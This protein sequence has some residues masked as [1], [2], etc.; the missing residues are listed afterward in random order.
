MKNYRQIII[1]LIIGTVIG[2]SVFEI[3]HE[4]DLFGLGHIVTM[5]Q[6]KHEGGGVLTN[7]LLECSTAE[8]D[9]TYPALNISKP[10]LTSFVNRM[11]STNKIDFISVY[12]RDLNNGPWIGINEKEEFLGS[13]L[14]KVPILISYM[15]SAENDNSLLDKKIKYT[16]KVIDDDQYYS[17]EKVLEVGGEYTVKDLLNYMIYYSD[18]NAANL[19]ADS[20]D[21]SEMDKVFE[22]LGL[23]K[24]VFNTPYPVNVRNYA[25]F[26]RIL[27]NASYVNKEYSEK[28]LEILTHTEFNR[29]LTAF[30]PK[31]IVVAHKF[32]IRSDNGVNQLHDCG[33]V[34]Y[35][36][37]PYLICI[38]SRGRNFDDLASAIAQISEF[39][40]EEVNGSDK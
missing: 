14:L 37:H 5:N 25:G 28:T 36:E 21:N 6:E 24:P 34:Y 10:A 23:G 16:T 18:N 30:L 38:M 35:P 27:F 8:D 39:V 2:Y 12:V 13:S 20:M 11:V 19:L 32:G 31:D 26:F 9:G 40:F 22:A 15:K 3:V 1:G 4:K 29:G 33:I 17:P 7:P